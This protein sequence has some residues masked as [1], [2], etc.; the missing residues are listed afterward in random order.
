M[1]LFLILAPYGAFAMLMLVTSATLSL[2][3]GTAMCLASIGFDAARGRSLKILPVTSAILFAGIAVWLNVI[4]PHVSDKA[5]KLAVDV[6][7]FAVSLGS[8]LLR[9]PFTTQY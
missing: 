9:F 5:V 7:M 8:M 2:V 1:T 6:G 3:A 4:D